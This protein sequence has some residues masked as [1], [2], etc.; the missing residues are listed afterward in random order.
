MRFLASIIALATLLC[1]AH[2]A[3]PRSQCVYLVNAQPGDTCT[4]VAAGAGT[5][6]D[7]VE[8]INP[9]V[10]CTA[11]FK[12][13][14]PLCVRE[15]TPTCWAW[16]N[17]T[18]ATCDYLLPQFH[19]TKAQFVQNNDNVDENCDLMIG[20]QYCAT[21]DSCEVNAAKCCEDFPDSVYCSY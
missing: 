18:E 21:T 12:V 19:L 2:A 16:V 1:I 11:P 13:L 9:T 20:D 3:G 5:D 10:D 8:T 14:T 7:T 15:Y 17:A 4:S 6:I